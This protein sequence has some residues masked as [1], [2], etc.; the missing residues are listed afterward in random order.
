M[1]VAKMNETG[2]MS[3]AKMNETGLPIAPSSMA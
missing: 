2:F 3:V 1:S